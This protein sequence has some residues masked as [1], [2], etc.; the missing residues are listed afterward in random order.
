MLLFSDIN[1]D[2][3]IKIFGSDTPDAIYTDLKNKYYDR[4]IGFDTSLFK[5]IKNIVDQ[6][7]EGDKEMNCTKAITQIANMIERTH[8]HNIQNH[9]LNN[10]DLGTTSTVGEGYT[11]VLIFM[12]L[13]NFAV[14]VRQ[15]RGMTAQLTGFYRVIIMI[16]QDYSSSYFIWQLY[17]RPAQ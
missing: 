5:E 11:N 6:L 14:V 7:K 4:K 3:I 15:Y 12:D 8:D 13:G 10:S 16:L 17:T 2:D 9:L 1:D